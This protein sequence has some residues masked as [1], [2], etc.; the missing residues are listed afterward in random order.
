MRALWL[1]CL[2]GCT[3]AI[4]NPRSRVPPGYAVF[5]NQFGDCV[6]VVGKV[7]SPPKEQ[8]VYECRMDAWEHYQKQIRMSNSKWGQAE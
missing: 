5:T 2:M 1:V 3:P 8:S 6:F 4:D 7:T